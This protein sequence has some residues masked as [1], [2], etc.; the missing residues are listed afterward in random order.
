VTT[1]T[2]DAPI[3]LARHSQTQCEAAAGQ[4]TAL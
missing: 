3:A 2:S 4:A 1:T